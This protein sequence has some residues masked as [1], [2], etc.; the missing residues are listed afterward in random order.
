M[1]SLVG[2][3]IPR[4]LVYWRALRAQPPAAPRNLSRLPVHTSYVDARSPEDVLAAAHRCCGSVAT[5]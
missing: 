1:V 5:A 3:I 2:C 4:L